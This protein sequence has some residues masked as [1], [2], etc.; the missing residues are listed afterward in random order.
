MT[1]I[2]LIHKVKE[3]SDIVSVISDFVKLKKSG[4]NFVGCCPFHNEKT[5]SFTVSPK[6][7]I[8]KCF[9]CGAGGD[10]I[11]FLEDYEKMS[12]DEAVRLL[13]KRAK[14]ETSDFIGQRSNEQI[15]VARIEQQR[16]ESIL[17]ANQAARTHFQS[18]LSESHYKYFSERYLKKETV[19]KFQIGYNTNNP[20]LKKILSEYSEEIL[21]EASLLN[22]KEKR[23]FDYF[24]DERLMFPICNKFGKPIAFGART[25]KK[26]FKPK[27]INSRETKVYNKSKSLF[28]LHIA[29]R[30]ISSEKLAFV[31]EGYTDVMMMNQLNFEN[32]VGKCGTSFTTE[33][34]KILKKICDR[35]CFIPDSDITE[36]LRVT[37]DSKKDDLVKMS[38]KFKTLESE[39]KIALEENLSIEI[40]IIENGDVCSIANEIVHVIEEKQDAILFLS[41]YYFSK[42]STPFGQKKALELTAELIAKTE[43]NTHQFYINEIAKSYK[44]GKREIKREIEAFE[45]KSKTDNESKSNDEENLFHIKVRDT[46]F[47][48]S[49]EDTIGGATNEVYVARKRSEL[50]EEY[51]KEYVYAIPRF[52]GLVVEPNHQN[53]KYVI[54]KTHTS[55]RTSGN[56]KV[57]KFI[58]WYNPIPYQEK[59]FDIENED[60]VQAKI[61]TIMKFYNHIFSD[62]YIDLGLDYDSILYKFPKQKLPAMAMV[63]KKRK[64]GKSTYMDFHKEIFGSNATMASVGRLTGNFNKF[65]QGKLLV[66]IEETRDER[67]TAENQLKDLIT[68]PSQQIEGK[69]SDS[70]TAKSYLKLMFTSNYPDTFLKI[71]DNEDRFIVIEVPTISKTEMDNKLK[72]KIIAEIPYYLHY[73][74][75]RKIVHQNKERLWFEPK[76]YDTEALRRVKESSINPTIASI[77]ELIR[78]I[79]LRT[80]NL[81]L[82]EFKL[83]SKTL[84]TYMNQFHDTKKYTTRW[85]TSILKHEGLSST[86]NATNFKYPQI[87]ILLD[88]WECVMKSQKARYFKFK[89]NDYL[90]KEEMHL[91]GFDTNGKQLELPI[92]ESKTEES[93]TE[94]S[95]ENDIPQGDLPF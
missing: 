5:P 78:A 39:I 84:A 87:G 68:N 20:N 15:E 33:H 23:V 85:L 1:Y 82:S 41:D 29:K 67:G 6:K 4:I 61:G 18:Q 22:R 94:E 64:T 92:Q 49:I 88:E 7:G 28:G 12:V 37:K 65:L 69:G 13:A 77:N 14:I 79:F 66:C 53:F 17:I 86:K 36:I 62:K 38:R 80:D 44:I 16:E 50:T 89:I 11:K 30:S 2:K 25:L 95:D 56:S 32:T 21:L 70:F 71:T 81:N 48:L 90:N 19:D 3:E 60:E 91:L 43:S 59:E 46:F 9:G 58:N 34:A 24:Y 72:E 74:A 54:E 73:L 47:E 63:S 93:K 26:D 10:V 31:V 55:K 35:V 51:G 76:A 8:Y 42:D 27:Y 75:N 57:Y 83:S 40:A 45:P 52:N